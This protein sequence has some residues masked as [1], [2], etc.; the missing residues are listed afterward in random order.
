MNGLPF[1]SRAG[2]TALIMWSKR[3]NRGSIEQ[4]FAASRTLSNWPH[5]VAAMIRPADSDCIFFKQVQFLPDFCEASQ[6]TGP[7]TRVALTFSTS[8]AVNSHKRQSW[9]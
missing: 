9:L 6:Q 2:N 5:T 1:N 3:L 4:L 8:D 7:L